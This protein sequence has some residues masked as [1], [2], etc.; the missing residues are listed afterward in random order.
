VLPIERGR[1]SEQFVDAF[2][3]LAFPVSLH[4]YLQSCAAVV[5]MCDA[6]RAPV[7]PREG[8]APAGVFRGDPYAHRRSPMAV[9]HAHTERSFRSS[10]TLATRFLGAVSLGG[11][12]AVHLQQYEYLYSDIPTIGTLFLLNFIGATALAVGLVVPVE[13]LLGS[14]GGIA[15]VLL[16]LGGIGLAATAFT[17]LLISERTPLFGFM[18]PGYD[19]AAIMAARVFEVVTV[20][21]LGS[22]LIVR[23]F[24]KGSFARW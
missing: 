23:R 18:E 16:A 24:G 1:D 21:L 9:T 10:A 7:L 22:F 14:R 13:R 15:V 12:G 8:I 4:R 19:P 17:F 2:K 11:V 6:R 5:A 20:G 3:P